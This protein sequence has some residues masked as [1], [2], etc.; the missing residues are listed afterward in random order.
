MSRFAR[1][2][3][4]FWW[5][6]CGEESILS[7]FKEAK[8][9]GYALT[10][11]QRQ[12][13]F[14][15]C[16]LVIAAIFLAA[17]ACDA[18][19]TPEGQVP[20]ATWAQELNKYPGLMAEIGQLVDK[21]QKNVQFPAARDKSRLLPLLPEAT[22]SYA[23]FPNYGDAAHQAL[24]IF[25]QELAESPVLSDW[26]QHGKVSAAGPK[27]EDSLEKFYQLSQYLGEE[28]VVS[29][30]MEG[31]EP[32]LLMVAEVRKPG[33]KTL[34]QQMVHEFAGKAKPGVRVLD[35]QE[36]AI[37]K[38]GGPAGEFVL[39][40]RPD[41]VVGAL[42]LATLRRFNARLEQR[43]QGFAATPFGQRVVQAYEGGVTMLAAADVHKILEQVP[44]GTQQSQ[45]TFQHSGFADMKFVVWEHKNVSGEEVSEGELSFVAA[46]HGMASWLG[47][48]VPLGSLE[49][50]SPNAML[51]GTMVLAN[52]RQIFEDVKEL[53][54]ASNP[55]AF[56]TLE[57]GEQA[58]KLS[59]KE[60]LLRYL[61][62]E[63]TVE[64]D[65]VTP[66]KPEWKAILQVN[67]PTRLQ[68]TLS[69]L[70]GAAQMRAE[71]FDKGGVTYN[72][73]RIPSSPT[74]FEIGYAF[75][76][77]YLIAG[78]S[79]ETVAEAVRLHRSGESLGK[80]KKFLASL[81]PGHAADASALLYQDP[82]AMTAL[83]LR[84]VAP[85]MAESLAQLAGESTPA[86][87]C[88]YGEEKGI[89]EA[90][91]SGTLDV[92]V[93]LVVAAIAIPN[94][95]RSRMAANEGSAVGR[96]RTVNVAQVTYAMTYPKRIYAPNLATLGPDPRRPTAN[97]ED[98]ANLIDET[99]A[100]E[101]CT[102]DAWCTKSG[103]HFRLTAVCKQHLC[104][105]YVVVATP[106]DSNTGARSFC[107]TSDGVIR[108]KMGPP[109]SS[110]VSVSE[111]R[112]WPPLQ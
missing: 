65:N 85:E 25:R 33:L 11:Q 100:N 20:G 58:L 18:Q 110:P 44:P 104:K 12:S 62:G 29:G 101:S 24:K 102:G 112:A 78:S 55:N 82:I 66:P 32:H 3:I 52:P 64:L 37:A 1:P 19:A 98:H 90:S 42:D 8:R 53:L 30:A 2:S 15:K 111:C 39:L 21:L 4:A 35:S 87:V 68:Q 89:R 107:S 59:L 41:Y 61:G 40:V 36:L 103:F 5:Q 93:V 60:D 97:S 51:A 91:K 47:K 75:V 71:Q 27:V 88:V 49:F 105:E 95:L 14:I 6:K 50:V 45:M 9:M 86:V 77:G 96:V 10:L 69:T 17:S 7:R 46:R 74:S 108:F 72:T 48:P 26:W 70:L 92:A 67:D 63:I 23:A 43:S 84:Q 13:Y 56:A 79:H 109:L 31:R 28:L 38:D 81:P 83:R 57:Q 54:T 80:S 16:V 34:L 76:D 106:I 99:L 73:L 94:L 22:M